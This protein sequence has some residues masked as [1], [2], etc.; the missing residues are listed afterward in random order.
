MDSLPK[1]ELRLLIDVLHD[2][3]KAV[4]CKID[5]IDYLQYA[6]F[7]LIGLRIAKSSIEKN[8]KPFKKH[9]KKSLITG[10]RTVIEVIRKRKRTHKVLQN[11]S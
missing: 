5:L 10:E 6:I 4:S 8:V 1:K 2:H 11:V 3:Y 9:G 7:D